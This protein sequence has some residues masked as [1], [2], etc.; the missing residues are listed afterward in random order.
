MDIVIDASAIASVEDLADNLIIGASASGHF[1]IPSSN[2]TNFSNSNAGVIV[3]VTDDGRN[4]WTFDS[5][6]PGLEG[7][8]QDQWSIKGIAGTPESSTL[9]LDINRPII[10]GATMYFTQNVPGGSSVGNGEVLTLLKQD[11]GSNAKAADGTILGATIGSVGS[12]VALCVDF[13]PSVWT[14]SHSGSPPYRNDL[15]TLLAKYPDVTSKSSNKWYREYLNF[16]KASSS[17]ILGVNSG[18]LFNIWVDAAKLNMTT[19]NFS[20]IESA[21]ASS[22]GLVQVTLKG[23]VPSSAGTGV[24]SATGVGFVTAEVRVTDYVYNEEI[25][26]ASCRERVCHRV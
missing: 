17:N 26:R 5:R 4:S 25:G 11:E 15:D 24:A 16:S 23:T 21:T 3:T 22:N 10:L 9:V 1:S 6:A 20:T 7:G 18:G 13:M 19:A 12:E 14:S 8:T 2:L